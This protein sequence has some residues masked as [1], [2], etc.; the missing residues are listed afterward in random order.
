MQNELIVSGRWTDEQF[1]SSGFPIRTESL[2]VNEMLLQGKSLI[3]KGP[4]YIEK[5][6]KTLVFHFR[7]EIQ[8]E[9]KLD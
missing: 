4:P 2:A 5:L 3:H 8:D 1:V 7:K 9:R 6:L